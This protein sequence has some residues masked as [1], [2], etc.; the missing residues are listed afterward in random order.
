MTSFRAFAATALLAAVSAPAQVTPTAT[1]TTSAPPAD[2]VVSLSPFRA[3]H[4][5]LTYEPF[6]TTTIRIEGERGATH[7]V[8]ADSALAINDVAAAG[9]GFS[10][11]NQW[12]YTSDGEIL[13]R[14]AT[15]PPAAIDR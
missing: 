1:A 10:S 14:T 12:Y 9:R 3:G 6:K 15:N 8:R 11:N 4:I 7:R 2:E 5:A 13:Q